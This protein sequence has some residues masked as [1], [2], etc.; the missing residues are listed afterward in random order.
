MFFVLLPIVGTRPPNNIMKS[1][2][3]LVAVVAALRSHPSRG[4]NVSISAPSASVVLSSSFPEPDT[5]SQFES[6]MVT[7]GRTYPGLGDGERASRKLVWLDNHERIRSH[8]EGGGS[9]YTM[10]HNDFSDM[11][12]QEFRHRFYLG[13]YSPGV[14]RRGPS[15]GRYDGREGLFGAAVAAVVRS[16]SLRYDDGDGDVRSSRRRGMTDGEEGVAAGLPPSQ[17]GHDDKDG[18][19]AGAFCTEIQPLLFICQGRTD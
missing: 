10:G 11:T 5:H 17:P 12:G 16:S 7:Y 9:S 2:S 6:W 8:N 13:E 3:I 18:D 14:A 19:D 15:G 1:K 4:E